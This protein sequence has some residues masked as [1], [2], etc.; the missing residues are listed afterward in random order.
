MKIT[1]KKIF[2]AVSIFLLMQSV[3][4]AQCFRLFHIERNK[5]NSIVCYDLTI[6]GSKSIDKSKPIDVYWEMPDKDNA[7]NTLSVIQNKLAYGFTIDHVKEN[8]ILFKLK[9][10][11]ER[12][13]EAVYDSEKKQANAYTNINGCY[14]ILKKLY[15]HAIPPLY[16]SVEY[17]VLVGL[18]PKTGKEVKEKIVNK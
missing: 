18:D 1:K 13:V 17:I 15:I 6:N 16:N 8:L 5:N 2:L 11:P 4:T 14:A 9:A 12:T 3:A 10:Y 7:R